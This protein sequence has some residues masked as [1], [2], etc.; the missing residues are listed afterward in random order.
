MS[1]VLALQEKVKV[2]V[3]GR[4]LDVKPECL[5]SMGTLRRD[6]ASQIKLTQPNSLQV[7]DSAGRVIRT[8]E[9][10][11][12]ALREARYPLQ[13]KLTVVA[14][15]EIEQKKHEA[16]AKKEELVQLQWQIVVEQVGQLSSELADCAGQLQA[17]KDDCW[18]GVRS[19]EEKEELRRLQLTSSIQHETSEREAGQRDLYAQ[20]E[21]LAQMISAERCARDVSDHQLGKRIDQMQADMDLERTTRAN[22]MAELDR[23]NSATRHDLELES[24]KN[25]EGHSKS[26][27]W[28]KRHEVRIDDHQSTSLSLQ[29]RLQQAEVEGEKQRSLM[30]NMET[31]LQ[32]HHRH[33]KADGEKRSEELQRSIR[34][35]L[36]SREHD[37]TRL[38]K[39]LETSWQALEVRVQK[40]RDEAN[41]GQL[42]IM[43]RTR[44]LEHR[45]TEV[46]SEL[47]DYRSLQAS[48][49]QSLNDS[50]SMAVSTAD[51]VAVEKKS[52]DVILRTM[53]MKLEDLMARMKSAENDIG[54]KSHV[55]QHKPHMD[56]F[57]RALQKQEAKIQTLE[58]DLN[59]RITQEGTHRDMVKAQLT[60]S[61]R[62]SLEKVASATI[63]RDTRDT[64][65][66]AR[67]RQVSMLDY[68]G[69]MAIEAPKIPQSASLRS[70]AMS[71]R[72]SMQSM[73]LE[74]HS[75]LMK[76][77]ATMPMPTS[78]VTRQMSTPTSGQFSPR[79]PGQGPPASARWVH[80]PQGKGGSMTPQMPTAPHLR[81]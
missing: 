13:A 16:E 12:Y 77:A 45:A 62:T 41:E 9:D 14:V 56:S 28:Q 10:L 58:R 24:H 21:R 53:T 60:D 55:E 4:L 50:V 61:L 79:H 57:Y 65:D 23:K 74:V 78:L 15:H 5:V 72:Q 39:D 67:V 76:S 1:V 40:S 43:E 70:G 81:Q 71:P 2:S 29:Q 20:L 25:S 38:A 11:K 7:A 37:V 36:L 49:H 80:V 48:K 59:S 46:E 75:G 26:F 31:A 17:V 52:N 22:S 42:M 3:C 63:P 35:S 47:A 68:Q 19:F 6:L 66:S 64:T 34:D 69:G 8:D 32:A 73:P 18:K 44:A 33:N 54:E 30:T 27:E 51:T